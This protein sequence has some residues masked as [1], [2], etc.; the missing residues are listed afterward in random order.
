M[1]KLVILIVSLAFIAAAGITA[2]AQ[3]ESITRLLHFLIRIEETIK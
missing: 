2:S 1:K 3:S